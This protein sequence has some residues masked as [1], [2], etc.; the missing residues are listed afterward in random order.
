MSVISARR[1]EGQVDREDG[2]G[3]STALATDSQQ[4]IN[5]SR[6]R[7]VCREIERERERDSAQSCL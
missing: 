6:E 1:G 2:E 4:R 3:I 7:E 5:R